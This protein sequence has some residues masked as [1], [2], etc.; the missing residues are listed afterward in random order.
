MSIA[1]G[2]VG[3]ILSQRPSFDDLWVCWR[4]ECAGACDP[5]IPKGPTWAQRLEADFQE[6][7][8]QAD[9]KNDTNEEISIDLPRGSEFTFNQVGYAWD[10][11][12]P[13]G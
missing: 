2:H 9:E 7:K 12:R 8:G 13:L 10:D 11:V 1:R 4:I 6:I 3:P 5:E